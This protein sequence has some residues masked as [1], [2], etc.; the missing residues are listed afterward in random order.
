MVE[1]ADDDIE[2]KTRN[3]MRVAAQRLQAT[4][5]VTIVPMV[6]HRTC[7]TSFPKNEACAVCG[8]RLLLEG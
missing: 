6:E 3:A 8:K 5:P 4:I 1:P 7:G 2:P